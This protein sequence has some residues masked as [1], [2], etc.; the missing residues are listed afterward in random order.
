MK[1]LPNSQVSFE[2]TATK[3]QLADFKVEAIKKLKKD[4]DKSAKHIQYEIIQIAA[5][6]LYAQGVT[7]NKI[8]PVAE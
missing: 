1:Q 6:Q 3:A 5:P 2:I 4:Q 8:T 7:E